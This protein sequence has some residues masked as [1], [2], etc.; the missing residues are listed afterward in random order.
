MSRLK[1]SRSMGAMVVLGLWIYFFIFAF[2]LWCSALHYS[3]NYRLA[4]LVDGQCGKRRNQNC[5]LNSDDNW[6]FCLPTTR[7]IRKGLNQ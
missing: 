6:I 2:E 7:V 5:E 3:M 1:V 4:R